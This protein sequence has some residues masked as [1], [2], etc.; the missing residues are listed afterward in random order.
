MQDQYELIE[1]YLNGEFTDMELVAFENAMQTD[2]ALRRLVKL[3]E[4]GS[5]ALAQQV[6]TDPHQ[7][8]LQTTLEQLGKQYFTS[9]KPEKKPSPLSIRTRRIWQFAVAAS[10]LLLIFVGLKWYANQYYTTEILL[11]QNYRPASVPATRSGNDQNLLQPAYQAYRQKNYTEALR[12][13]AALS[14]ENPQYAEAQLFSGYAYFESRQYTQAIQAFDLVLQR[15]DARYHDNAEWHRLLAALAGKDKN[16]NTYLS[17]ILT[18][19]QHA[20]YTEAQRLQKQ[21][22]SW[23]YDLSK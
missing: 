5:K 21:M 13:F 11:A 2:A 18:N 14:P 9:A 3:Y 4:T 16:S 10:I 1:K 6:A 23:L 22:K 20:Y 12:I 15:N 7:A 17:A 8:T 19:P